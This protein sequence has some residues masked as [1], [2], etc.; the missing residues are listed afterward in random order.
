MNVDVILLDDEARPYTSYQ[1]ILGDER[2]LRLGQHG[3]DIE[4]P[5]AQ[6]HRQSVARQNALA[7]VQREPTKAQRGLGHSAHGFRTIK[8]DAKDLNGPPWLLSRSPK[9]RR[10]SPAWR[11]IGRRIIMTMASLA[12][13]V[14]AALVLAAYSMKDPRKMRVVA[15]LSNIAFITYGGLMGL[16]PVLGLHLLLLPL[17]SVRLLQLRAAAPVAA[18]VNLGRGGPTAT[19]RPQ[20]A[21]P[22]PESHLW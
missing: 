18:P 21:S 11:K 9:D 17:N 7:K 19:R 10:S 13:Y 2:S 3:Q 20:P 6:W 22:L 14:P 12:C 4:S 15:I 5:A 8:K 16:P 1:H